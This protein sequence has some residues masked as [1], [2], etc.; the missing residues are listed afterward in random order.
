M[1]FDNKK[2]TIRIYLRKMI[3]ASVTVVLLLG[4]MVSGWF[5]NDVLGISKYQWVIL[6]TIVYILIITFS[7]MRFLNFIS[8][9]DEGDK[10]QIRYH[11]I[12]PLVQ[13]KNVIKIPKIGLAFYEIKSSMLGL[14]KTLIIGQK[15][16]GKV[17]KY[18]PIGISALNPKEIDLL[19]KHLD[20][21]IR[22]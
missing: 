12:H 1:K 16:K 5:E 7:R 2:T 20:L 22:D 10:I 6:V 15:V 3:I 8:Y 13:K 19:R 21:F 18:P 4:I 17:A 11:P 14:K 9:T